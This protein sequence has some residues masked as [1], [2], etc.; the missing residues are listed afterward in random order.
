MKKLMLTAMLLTCFVI[1]NQVQAQV[2]VN[3]NVNVDAQP[4]WGPAGYDRVDY[5]YLPDIESYY[6][7]PRHQF[8]YLDAGR[9]IF[10]A[11]LP[12]RCRSYDLYRGYKVVINEPRPYLHHDVYRTRYGHY[13]GYYDH[14]PVLH[15]HR[16]KHDYD[17]D[18]DG[19]GNGHGRGH[20]YGHYK[21]HKEGK[22]D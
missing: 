19:P 5:Y 7:V 2:K 14:Q 9:W 3:V 13:C 15:D 16:N 4:G 21:G 17:Q 22:G 20:A 11:S 8:V 1:F 10:A 6:Y 12:G 18:D